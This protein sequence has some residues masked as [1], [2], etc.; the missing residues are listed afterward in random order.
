M[1]LGKKIKLADTECVDA[2]YRNSL[3][4][5]K[6][7]DLECLELIFQV[8]SKVLGKCVSIEL[9]PGGKDMVRRLSA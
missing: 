7:N 8:D 6:E 1:M 2:E 9:I 3:V 4:W 5:I